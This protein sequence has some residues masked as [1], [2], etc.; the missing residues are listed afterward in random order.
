MRCKSVLPSLRMEDRL[1]LMALDITIPKT[2]PEIMGQANVKAVRRLDAYAVER[3]LVS[4]VRRNFAVEYYE[5]VAVQVNPANATK[6]RR[7]LLTSQ[8]ENIRRKLLEQS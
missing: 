5:P 7:Y 3:S 6:S 8:G 2:V 4:L 1:A